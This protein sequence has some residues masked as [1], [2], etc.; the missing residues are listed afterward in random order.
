[1]NSEKKDKNS[2]EAKAAEEEKKKRLRNLEAT[3]HIREEE[4]EYA[5][6]SHL[7]DVDMEAEIEQKVQKVYK[8]LNQKVAIDKEYMSF[9]EINQAYQSH[10]GNKPVNHFE[11]VLKSATI[12]VILVAYFKAL[13]K[14]KEQVK[15]KRR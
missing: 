6:I 7:I 10:M 13:S 2:K 9:S 15:K 14:V 5:K 12:H 3:R 8:V 11:G 1:M 4:A